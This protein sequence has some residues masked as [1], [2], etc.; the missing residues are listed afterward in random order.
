M[1]LKRLATNFTNLSTI[2]GKWFEAFNQASF[3]NYDTTT[4][5]IV[6]G[7]LI[8]PPAMTVGGFVYPTVMEISLK[9][10]QV[11]DTYFTFDFR[12]STSP[13]LQ[14]AYTEYLDEAKL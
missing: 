6:N 1:P 7:S 14:V 9:T 13:N 8:I 11:N 3:F 2:Q 10:D 5:V 4:A 12:G